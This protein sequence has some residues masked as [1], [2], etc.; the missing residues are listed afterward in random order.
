MRTTSACVSQFLTTLHH[1]G[2]LTARRLLCQS[3]LRLAEETTVI[4]RARLD[5]PEP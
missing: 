4:N 2:A 5:A 3:S 1:D